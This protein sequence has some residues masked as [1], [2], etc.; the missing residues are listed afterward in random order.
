MKKFGLRVVLYVAANCMAAG[1][2]FYAHADGCEYDTQCKGDRIC[3][4]KICVA[5]QPANQAAT[6]QATTI[7][8]TTTAAPAAKPAEHSSGLLGIF[9]KPQS[10]TT[11]ATYFCCTIS[12]R[13]GPFPN[14]ESDGKTYRIGDACS[15]TSTTARRFSGKVCN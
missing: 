5:P 8:A 2:P 15:G 9:S 6:T 11:D 14:P 7:Q 4:N 1:L 3:E 10:S 13:L 12:E